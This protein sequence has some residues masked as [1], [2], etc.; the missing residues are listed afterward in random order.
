MDELR[1]V[2][3]SQSLVS[4]GVELVLEAIEAQS[5]ARRLRTESATLR[6]AR[7]RLSNEITFHR[8]EF[9]VALAAARQ[10]TYRS[11]WSTLEWDVA[12]RADLAHARMLELVC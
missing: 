8:T 5:E 10:Q 2:S 7:R 9:L 3:R 6:Q 4:V 1:A 12:A 11:A